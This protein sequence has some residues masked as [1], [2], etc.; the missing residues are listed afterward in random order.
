IIAWLGIRPVK[1]IQSLWERDG[2]RPVRWERTRCKGR[3]IGGGVDH[4]FRRRGPWTV[5]QSPS[6]ISVWMR[7]E[8]VKEELTRWVQR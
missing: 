8:A 5:R 6:L 4:E 7:K 2:S 3:L 1:E